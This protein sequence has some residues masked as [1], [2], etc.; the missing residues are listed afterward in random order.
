MRPIGALVL[1]LPLLLVALPARGA[2]LALVGGDVHT[3]S[4]AVFPGATVLIRNERIALVGPDVPV[5]KKTK[6][7][8]CKG[9]VV[10]P[11]LIESD[12]SLGLVEISLVEETVDARPKLHDPVRAAVSAADAIDM[13]STLIAVARRHGVTSAVS[14]PDGGLISGRSAWIDLLGTRSKK[15]AAAV[16]PGVAMIASLGELGA[17]A[18]GGSRA[19]AVTRLKE[20]L[21]DA[22]TY[23]RSKAAFTRRAL[24]DLSISRLDAEALQPVLARRIPLVLRVSRASDIRTALRTARE[25][26]IDVALLGAEEGWL[27]ADEIARARV[28]V[29]LDA[30]EN[31]PHRFESRYARADNA[32]LLAA[33]GVK[34]AIATRSSHNASKLRFALGNAVRAGLPKE[35]ALRAATLSPAEIFGK[36]E[37]YGS[38]DRGK[39][40]N[41]VV[42]SGDPFQP[43]SHAVHVI[44]RGEPQP[45]RSRQTALAEKHAR[46]LGLVP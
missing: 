13:R 1:S 22:R 30:F 29:I 20:A 26:R 28:P 10:T 36:A 3:V 5:P 31:I 17:G 41:V 25:E 14:A 44:V 27:V 23:Q 9:M 45:T 16:E 8:D 2:D 43:A 35:V 4:G 46:R 24:Y 42:W 19:V 12:S 32:A 11:G 40:A 37:M 6:T 7:I 39:M 33:A 21:D 38:L 15:L 18:S 34:V